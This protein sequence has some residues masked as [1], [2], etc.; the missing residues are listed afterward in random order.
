MHSNG[1]DSTT[2]YF[3]LQNRPMYVKHDEEILAIEKWSSPRCVF[4][5]FLNIHITNLIL[6]IAIGELLQ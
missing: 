2:I 1:C 6:I 4:E 3:A 5:T